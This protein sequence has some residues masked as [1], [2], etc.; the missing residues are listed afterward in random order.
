[1]VSRVLDT[2]PSLRAQAQHDELWGIDLK[3]NEQNIL[4][5]L[6]EKVFEFSILAV[7]GRSY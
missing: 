5:A 2:L 1:M 3:I 4:E 6:V 7:N